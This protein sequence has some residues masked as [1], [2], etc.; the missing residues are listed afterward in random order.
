MKILAKISDSKMIVE[1][2]TTEVAH[3][4]GYTYESEIKSRG[5]LDVG[6]EIKVSGLFKA[7]NASRD[8]KDELARMAHGLREAAKK[9]D[10]INT[11]LEEPILV[12]EK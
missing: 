4:L 6:S 9:I 11:A 10:S 7:L 3:I 12:V 8:R 2:S 5:A 1:V